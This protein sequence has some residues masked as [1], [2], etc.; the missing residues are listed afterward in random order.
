MQMAFDKNQ[1]RQSMKAAG[2]TQK[3]LAKV[4]NK[5][6]RT[7]SRWLDPKLP[8]KSDFVGDLCL[9]IGALPTEFD[10]DWVGSVET[11]NVTRVSARISSASKNNYW[12]LKKIYNISEKEVVELAPTLFGMF[13]AAVLEQTNEGE[14]DPRK[15][16]VEILAEEYGYISETEML[17]SHPYELEEDQL[18]KEFIKEGKIFG[19]FGGSGY[20][21]ELSVNPFAKEMEKFVK[22]SK[23]VKLGVSP[24]GTCP[25]SRGSAISADLVNEISGNDPEISEAISLGE[26]KLFSKEFSAVAND[27]EKRIEWMKK[28]VIKEQEAKAERRKK[29]YAKYPKLNHILEDMELKDKTHLM[30][31]WEI[32]P[33]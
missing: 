4:L 19:G 1:Y 33:T 27:P 3:Q 32:E 11:E 16:A 24:G 15:L 30:A 5:D 25:N 21:T 9:A 20:S 7:I 18:S 12:L 23:R 14:N 17:G 2:V 13:I 6:L 26:V 31:R 28:C 22:N 8:I 29:L 10:P